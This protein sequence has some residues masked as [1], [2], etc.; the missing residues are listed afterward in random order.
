[1]A[2]LYY[3][4]DKD[5]DGYVQV[6]SPDVILY[7]QAHWNELAPYHQRDLPCT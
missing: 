2:L 1:M 7:L 5:S 6:N 4:P 3:Y